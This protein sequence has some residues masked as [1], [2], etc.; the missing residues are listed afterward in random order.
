MGKFLQLY[1]LLLLGIPVRYPFCTAYRY[2][3]YSDHC[4]YSMPAVQ[5][6]AVALLPVLLYSCIWS[7]LCVMCEI[8]CLLSL[9][10]SLPLHSYSLVHGTLSIIT[11]SVTVHY[12]CSHYTQLVG[13]PKVVV[14]HCM[15]S[16]TQ[17]PRSLGGVLLVLRG[18]PV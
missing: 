9:M 13:I 14:Q 2:Y 4:L 17:K 15:H 16:R 3:H 12:S 5:L 8:L 7:S 11:N 1:N 18:K 10:N 6:R